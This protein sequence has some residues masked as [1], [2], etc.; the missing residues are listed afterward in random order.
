MRSFVAIVAVGWLL[1]AA[2][3]ALFPSPV[4]GA[5]SGVKNSN[6]SVPY[7]PSASCAAAGCHGNGQAHTVWAAGD[8]HAKAYRIL[9]N[10]DSARIAKNLGLKDAAA[11]ANC[12]ACH[13]PNS[14]ACAPA[15]LPNRDG[16]GCDACHGPSEKWKTL[17]YESTWKSLDPATKASRGFRDLSQ[18]VSR[19]ENCASCHVGDRHRQVDHAMIA[20]GHP[21]LAFEAAKYH[22]SPKYPKHWVDSGSRL[23]AKP[24]IGS[25]GDELKRW[26]IGQVVAARATVRIAIGRLERGIKASDLAEQNCFACHKSLGNATNATGQ[27]DWQL[28]YHAALPV[29]GESGPSPQRVV[30]T[31][32]KSLAEAIRREQ[33]LTDWLTRLAIAPP[34]DAAKLTAALIANGERQSHWDGHAPHALG[35]AAVAHADARQREAIRTL[36]DQLRPY[37]RYPAT[38]NSPTA[39]D[40][41]AVSAIF[42]KASP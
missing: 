36:L 17:H 32:P 9:F 25:N 42:R 1:L 27:P 30:A 33:E 11:A 31:E 26:A 39:Y 12:L 10:D 41:A 7:S 38:A 19:I 37:L 23:A 2:G 18:P 20:A 4:A 6:S 22:D 28:W 8:P 29:V 34:P 5:G 40:P 3:S 21:R 15:D 24:Q 13:G 35:L 16:V 14:D